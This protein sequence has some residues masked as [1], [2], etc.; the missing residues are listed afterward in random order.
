VGTIKAV[1]GG[2]LTITTQEG[3]VRVQ[4]TDTTIIEKYTAVGVGDLGVGERVVI[5][6]SR[7]EDGSVTA[8][9]IQVLPASGFEQPSQP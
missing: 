6:G 7:N 5:S 1:E 9:S 4:T 8:R 2:A 3:T